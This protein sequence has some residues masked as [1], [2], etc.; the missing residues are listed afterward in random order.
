MQFQIRK[1]LALGFWKLLWRALHKFDAQ[2]RG[3]SPQRVALRGH[4]FRFDETFLLER[5]QYR[6]GVVDFLLQI[7]RR[8]W[9]CVQHAEHGG[10]R[11]IRI[12]RAQVQLP[13]DVTPR[14][15]QRVNFAAA[16]FTR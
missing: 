4:V 6:S 11:I 8:E 3:R 9:P 13:G 16:D 12:V 15:R 2:A 7:R 14:F 1:Q 10:R 5:L